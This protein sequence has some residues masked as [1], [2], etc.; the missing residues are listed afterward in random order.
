MRSVVLST[1]KGGISRLREK[2]GASPETLMMLRNAYVTTAKTIKQRPGF[3]VEFNLTPGT[4]G[5]AS[6]DGMFYTFAST[7]VA[8]ADPRV[9]TIVL[10]HPTIPALAIVK[11]H[12]SQ[13]FLGRFYVSAEFSNGDIRHYWVTNAPDWQADTVY[14]YQQ[15]V[16]PTTPNGFVYVVANVDGTQ[17]WAP[18]EAITVGQIRQ[19][20][21]YNGFK[22][23]A[24]A[25]VGTPPVM[26]SD[27]EPIWPTT[28][29]AQIVEYTYGGTTPPTT[30]PPPTTTYPPDVGDEYGP[31]PPEQDPRLGPRQVQ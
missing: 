11:V 16:V 23:E 21:T 29:G 27:V 8:H 15:Q 7:F 22:F 31:F 2:G 1:Q 13:P 30:P 5:L 9:E 12:F 4:V 6:F 10:K 20:R 18:G 14:G 25:I 26:T 28:E 17:A 24:V 3:P 19:P